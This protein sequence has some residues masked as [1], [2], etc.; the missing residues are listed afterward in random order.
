MLNGLHKTETLRINKDQE[1][2]IQKAAN[3]SLAAPPLASSSK[4]NRQLGN[5]ER[6]YLSANSSEDAEDAYKKWTQ[7]SLSLADASVCKQKINL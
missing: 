4:L 7:T 5:N 1:S 3:G 6:L 2:Y